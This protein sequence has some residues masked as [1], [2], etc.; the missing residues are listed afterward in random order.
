MLRCIDVM[1]LIV[2]DAATSI[3]LKDEW[4]RI[5]DFLQAALLASRHKIN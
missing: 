4:Q 1:T 5:N 2:F 3:K